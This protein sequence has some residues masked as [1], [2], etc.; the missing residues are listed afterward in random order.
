MS[1]TSMKLAV[2]IEAK[3]AQAKQAVDGLVASI[4]KVDQA[5]AAR[6]AAAKLQSQVEQDMAVIGIRSNREIR[7]EIDKVAAALRRLR[8]SEATA[9]TGEMSRASQAAEKRLRELRREMKGVS[10]D[11][12][13]L[14]RNSGMLS[15]TW[16]KLTAAW[17]SFQA[18]LAAGG[19]IGMIE[20]MQRLE[21][22]LLTTERTA[23]RAAVA[24][25]VIEQVA[26]D[27]GTP[28]LAVGDAYVKFSNAAQRVGGSQAQALKF[29]EALTKALVN[30]GASATTSGI[31]MMQLGQ[32][33]DA[34]RLAGDEFKSVAENAGKVLDYL[35]ESLG[36]SRGE[37]RK[38]SEDGQLTAEKLLKLGEASERINRDFEK[39]P[40]T[41]GQS[42]TRIV[43][44]FAIWGAKSEVVRASLSGL[45]AVLEF[46]AKNLGKVLATS[47]VVT[48]GAWVIAVGGVSVALEILTV[49]AAKA[50]AALSLLSKNPWVVGAT[51]AITAMIWLWDDLVGLFKSNDLAVGGSLKDDLT[52]LEI[53]LTGIAEKVKP[54]LEKVRAA[55]D[56]VRKSAEKSGKAVEQAYAA[57]A[58]Q[59]D[60]A[61]AEQ[62]RLVQ[63]RYEEEKRLIGETKAASD[64]RY[65]AEAQALI[66]SGQQQLQ[67]LRDAMGQKLTLLNEEFRIRKE[68]AL[69][70]VETERERVLVAQGVDNELLTKKREVL[71]QMLGDYRQHVN[72]LNSEAQRNLEAMRTIE[73]QK[74]QLTM[75]TDEKI[76]ALRQSA[77]G[78]YQA[79]QDKLKQLDELTSKGRQALAVGDSQLAEEYFRKV[80][81]NA[82]SAARAVTVDGKEMVTQQQAVATAIQKIT[83]AEQLAQQA[84]SSRKTAIGQ[85]AQA[86]QAEAQSL[87][88]TIGTLAAQWQEVSSQLSQG[89]NLTITTNVAL[90]EADLQ[91]LDTLIRQREVLLN[92]KSNVDELQEKVKEMQS[93]L[94][95]GTSSEHDIRDNADQVQSAL[96]ALDGQ[97]TNSTHY[98]HEYTIHHNA[99]GGWAD[100]GPVRMAG[101]GSVWQRIMGWVHGPGTPTSDSVRAMLSR[102]EFVLRSAAATT[103]ARVMP[104][105]LERF[106][107]ISSPGQFADLM[108][109]VSGMF[110]APQVHLAAGGPV[111]SA[112]TSAAPMP[113]GGHET[114]T[115][116]LQTGGKEYPVRVVRD[117]KPMLTGW[118]DELNRAAL[119]GA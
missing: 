34:N 25:A 106:N 53:R 102:T 54:A 27:T 57:T 111:S 92:I 37:L 80:I 52:D 72:A 100:N 66:G 118:L 81:E 103:A 67:I 117:D 89:V 35:A 5:A 116:F 69:R 51:V 82:S 71:G 77:M 12:T 7:E 84:M 83:E 18:V 44:S 78:E 91:K 15:T 4:K 32:A 14:N 109:Q 58:E 13:V 16:G 24:M 50:S 73:E 59:V 48:M 74:R 11:T 119:M 6:T 39:M 99:T 33:F 23:A 76:R 87:A 2:E 29:T 79:Y 108:R 26:Q 30:S 62:I 97:I 65:L 47:V 9:W 114:M 3:V 115:V 10:E 45:A 55:I 61:A 36:V 63:A 101:G 40:R 94:E 49:T 105:F 31:V 46:V 98:I 56:E 20:D 112:L 93:K 8:T 107:A 19:V 90:V 1:S 41:V 110:A 75:S 60:S 104:G 42:V 64:G 85:A 28:I 113:M 17:V 43:N 96:N 88:A 38:M 86:Q 22:R 68:V 70:M 95:A 21:S